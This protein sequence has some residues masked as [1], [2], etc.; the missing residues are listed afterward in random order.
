MP[1]T[2][3]SVMLNKMDKGSATVE[4]TPVVRHIPQ[5]S[6]RL[7]ESCK[8]YLENEYRKMQWLL[9]GWLRV[10]SQE[11][12]WEKTLKLSSAWQ[13]QMPWKSMLGRGNSMCKGQR[14][15]RSLA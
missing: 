15:R 2:V 14:V 12:M 7:S 13:E 1:G 3:Y 9:G 6:K 4:L 11:K 8:C 5:R 10:G